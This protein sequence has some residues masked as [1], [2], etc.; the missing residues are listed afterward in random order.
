MDFVGLLLFLNG[1]EIWKAEQGL[2]LEELHL[3]GWAVQVVSGRHDEVSESAGVQVIFSPIFGI[4]NNFLQ[5][6]LPGPR[7]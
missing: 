3:C 5:E 4:Y 1:R 6:Q 2:V 7:I